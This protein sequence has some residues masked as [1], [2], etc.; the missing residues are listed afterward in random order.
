M[1]HMGAG[2]IQV[3]AQA[4]TAR[5]QHRS[6]DRGAE[7]GADPGDARRAGRGGDAA[8]PSRNGRGAPACASFAAP[9]I[10][11]G[12]IV[13]AVGISLDITEQ[14]ATED[15]LRLSEARYRGLIEQSPLS[16][17]ILAPDGTTLQVNAAWERL[18]GVTLHEMEGYN[19]R[20]TI[21]SWSR[22]G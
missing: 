17:Q 11:D 22:A 19:I 7:R 6:A 20:A 16:V 10:L 5:S 21:A 3:G 12:A 14:R 1:E 13:G 8:H 15:A 4:A 18:W 2:S 9:V